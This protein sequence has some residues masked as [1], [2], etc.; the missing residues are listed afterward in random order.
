MYVSTFDYN[1]GLHVFVQVFLKT[2]GV[3]KLDVFEKVH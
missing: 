3:W 1:N 2:A